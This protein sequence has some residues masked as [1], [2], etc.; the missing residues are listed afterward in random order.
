MPPLDVAADD[1]FERRW[2]LFEIAC[3]TVILLIALAAMAGLT[4]TGPL[5]RMHSV[6]PTATVEHDRI[7]RYHAPSLLIVRLHDPM[8]AVQVHLAQSL[9]ERIDVSRISPRPL[10]VTVDHDGTLY[11][12]AGGAGGRLQFTLEPREVGPVSGP[13]TVGT[14]SLLFRQ[15]VLP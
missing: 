2:H 6:L 13:V 7:G 14:A 10:S 12:F 15:L 4:G 11:R 1:R 3:W 9:L 5:A 8:P